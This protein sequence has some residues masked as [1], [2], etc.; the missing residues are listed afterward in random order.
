MLKS[1]PRL[2]LTG[3]LA[4]TLSLDHTLKL[5]KR[6]KVVSQSLEHKMLLS[7]GWLSLINEDS[8]IVAWVGLNT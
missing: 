6:A 2:L 3:F 1:K 8:L 5:A 4:I 7:G